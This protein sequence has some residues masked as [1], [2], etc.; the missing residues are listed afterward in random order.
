MTLLNA[1]K[2]VVYLVFIAGYSRQY[3]TEAMGVLI[4]LHFL[5]I[6]SLVETILFG[7]KLA[8]VTSLCHYHVIF[9]MLLFNMLLL[10]YNAIM[11]L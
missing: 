9:F 3:C 6:F 10:C 8:C 7:A 1:L 11:V 5:F 2:F 4:G